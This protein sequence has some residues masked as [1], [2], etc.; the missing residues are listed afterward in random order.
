MDDA[1]ASN[2]SKEARGKRRSE[3]GCR[4]LSGFIILFFLLL[5]VIPTM[6]GC[7]GG[8]ELNQRAFVTGIAFDLYTGTKEK[9]GANNSGTNTEKEVAKKKTRDEPEASTE[10]EK[11]QIARHLP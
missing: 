3:Q 1:S 8:R 10:K 4:L 5:I 9:T 2:A 6:T 7:W 11:Y